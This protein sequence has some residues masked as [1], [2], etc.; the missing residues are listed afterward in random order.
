M[1]TLFLVSWKLR[2]LN[3]NKYSMNSIIP[4]WKMQGKI[5]QDTDTEACI[6]LV[7]NC[8]YQRQ[9]SNL[10][11]IVQPQYWPNFLSKTFKCK[12]WTARNA[13]F[14]YK[15]ATHKKY[16]CPR[17]LLLVL[18]GVNLYL[19]TGAEKDG[20]HLLS[21][22]DIVCPD[23]VWQGNFCHQALR[24]TSYTCIRYCWLVDTTAISTLFGDFLTKEEELSS[25]PFPLPLEI[26]NW[27]L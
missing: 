6:D 10:V 16:L 26:I 27:Q 23:V 11:Q 7:I 18:D 19:W 15:I 22:D 14:T 12:N 8:L 13:F 4:N 5:T 24:I 17:P 21:D 25:F 9:K 20:Q 3:L 2:H 1:P